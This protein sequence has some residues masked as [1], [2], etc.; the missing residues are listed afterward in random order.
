MGRCRNRSGLTARAVVAVV[1]AGCTGTDPDREAT[2]VADVG[3]GDPGSTGTGE[4]AASTST[5]DGDST[6]GSGTTTAGASADEDASDGDGPKLD[7][8]PSTEDTGAPMMQTPV[9]SLP[10][11][12]SVTFYER[13]GG[14]APEPYTFVV[15]GPELTVRLDDP[16]TPDHTDITGVQTEHYDVYYSDVDGEFDI[17]GA[18]LTISGVF[19]YAL[20]AG[21]GLNLAEISLNF[22]GK[23]PEFGNYVASFNALGD[24]SAP[25][26]VGNTIDGDLATHT[27]MG[28]TIGSDERLRVTLGFESSSGP[29]Q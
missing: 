2:G 14:D 9:R 5:G 22:E 15:D 20:P 8:A 26:T 16:L 17:D 7:V 13:S 23:P 10:G 4:N 18:Y 28:N 27:T 21:G 6:A 11:L 1:L 3:L 25:A 19:E 29:P 24:N 12:E